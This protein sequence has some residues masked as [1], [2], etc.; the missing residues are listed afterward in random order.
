[1]ATFNSERSLELVLKSIRQQ[2]YPKNK[3]EILIIDGGSTDNTLEISKRYKCKIF[4]N[5][6]TDQ[7]YGKFL[8]YRKAKGKYMLLIDSDEVLSDRKSIKNKV[9]SI[10]TN[11]SVQVAISTGLKKPS[12]YPD[13]NYY[14]NEFGDPFSYFMYRNSKDPLF[15]L[16]Q[17][18]KQY[19]V[20]YEDKDRAVFDFRGDFEPPFIELTAMAVMVNR[21]Y[22]KKNFPQ[23]FVKPPEHTHLFY[24]LN[25]KENLF[26]I[27]KHDPV[28][29]YSVSTLSGYLRKIRSRITSNIYATGMGIAGFS[30][31]E[32]YHSENFKIKK[33]LFLIYAGSLFLP[34]IDGI[35][36]TLTRRRLVYLIHPLLTYYTVI[37]ILF[38]YT[39]KLFGVKTKL[40]TYGGK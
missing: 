15:F 34:I 13:I 27:M 37:L 1:M 18:K 11:P 28:I 21:E 3:I 22:I 23:V 17:M 9:I 20:V 30:G 36:L 6:K 31:R 39:R 16:K 33:Y 29:H 5:P 2:D 26:A 32:V 8:G 10:L 24:L 35:F 19:T 25:S 12:S 40:Y 38:F 14:L 7:V 4:N